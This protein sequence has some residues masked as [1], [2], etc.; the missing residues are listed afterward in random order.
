MS[1]VEHSPTLDDVARIIEARSRAAPL[2]LVKYTRELQIFVERF[3][4]TPHSIKR[5]WAASPCRRLL[6]ADIATLTVV[7]NL[8]GQIARVSSQMCQLQGYAADAHVI[9]T[10]ALQ[11]M[12]EYMEVATRILAMDCDPYVLMLAVLQLVGLGGVIVGR[13]KLFRKLY[14]EQYA[15]GRRAV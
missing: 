13:F 5:Q 1:A 15:A 14:M 7:D 3:C 4:A 12:N 10:V 6:A 8:I 9:D 11:R 2:A